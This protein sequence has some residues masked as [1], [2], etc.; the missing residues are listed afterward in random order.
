L[1][2]EDELAAAAA[3]YSVS[4]VNNLGKGGLFVN[5]KKELPAS[6]SVVDSTNQRTPRKAWLILAVVYFASLMAPLAQF[7]LPPLATWLIPEFA[8][9][10]VTFGYLMSALSVIG[11]LLAFPAAFI[12]RSIGLKNVTLL[13]V[14]CLAIG[15]LISVTT[16][17]LT[18]FMISRMVEGIGIG[19]IGISAPT[20]ISVWFPNQT[21]GLALGIWATWFP[22]GIT[23]MFNTAPSIANSFGWRSVFWLCFAIAVIAFVLFALVFKLP[24]GKKGDMRVTGSFKDGLTYLQNRK[25]W[26]LGITFFV[27][28]FF[29]LGIINSFYN[30]FLMATQGYSE[31]AA[32]SLTSVITIISI[33]AIPVAGAISDRVPLNK[34]KYFLVVCYVLFF[35]AFLFAWNSGAHATTTM[36]AF[37]VTVGIAGGLGGGVSR[38]MV[39]PLM[40]DTAM[41]ATMGM[42][43]FQLCQNLGAAIGAPLFG[44]GFENL[45]WSVAS[46]VLILPLC[47]LASILAFFVTPRAKKRAAAGAKEPAATLDSD[48]EAV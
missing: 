30:T 8:M 25:I 37:I 1:A 44:W 3:K 2:R 34:K 36:W 16:E 45:G 5:V 27:F 48:S 4:Q 35:I 32:A 26:I 6:V 23:L 46:D 28:N 19:L 11:V 21:R 9:D 39:P 17:S 12:C 24:E 20:C 38:S 47:L 41:G 42:A 29:Q 18:L 13:S 14:A 43:V 33:F 31:V 40:G 10:G 22:I 7:K 15:T